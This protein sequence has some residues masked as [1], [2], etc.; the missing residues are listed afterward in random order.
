MQNNAETIK[1]L[2]LML[3][4]LTSWKDMVGSSKKDKAAI[5]LQSWK[6]YDFAALDALKAEELIFGTDKEKAVYFTDEVIAR[7]KELLAEYGV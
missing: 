3:L 6:G 5:P 4:Y 1:D 2:T 7:A